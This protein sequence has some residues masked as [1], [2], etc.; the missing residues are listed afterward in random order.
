MLLI[1]GPKRSGK[2]TISRVLTKL[3]G[4]DNVVAP[5]LKSLSS[6]FGIQCLIDKPL[7]TITD[8]R[9]VG[10]QGAGIQHLLSISG[11]D[12]VTIDIKYKNPITM[13]LP[14]RFMFCTNEVPCLKD[15]SGA[16]ARR[17]ITLEMEE[18]FYGREDFGLTDRLN[19]ELPGILNWA[20]KGYRIFI[21]RGFL[22]QPESSK[23]VV[24]HMETLGSL[25]KAFVEK[26][27]EVGENLYVET[28]CLYM[29]YISWR[30]EHKFQTYGISKE[31]FGR[32]LKAV[33]PNLKVG[34]KRI[35]HKRVRVYIGIKLKK[36]I[37]YIS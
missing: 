18:S 33:L 15:S 36:K 31:L 8:A 10:N 20:I 24:D 29:C 19:S 25:I 27:C 5:S 28:T 1:I 6:S 37:P 21:K 14:T 7:A 2:G 11:E 35:Q 3:I 22:L 17:F 23:S 34:Q 13:K 4:E 16:V 26:R 12:F 32:D 9:V 30:E